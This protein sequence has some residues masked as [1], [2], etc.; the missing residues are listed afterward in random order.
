MSTTPA[1]KGKDGLRD[2]MRRALAITGHSVGILS[3]NQL[4]ELALEHGLPS[5]EERERILAERLQD[6]E[7]DDTSV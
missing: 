1:K 4:V 3:L 2:Q 5:H 6:A 7:G